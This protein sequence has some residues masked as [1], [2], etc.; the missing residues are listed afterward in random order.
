MKWFLVGVTFLL[1]TVV[2]VVAAAPPSRPGVE[3]PMRPSMDSGL[4]GMMEQDARMIERMNV[5]EMP[6]MGTMI[7]RDPMWVDPAMIRAQEQ[8]QSQ[9]DRMIAR[10]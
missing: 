1:L 7:E 3:P 8:Y 2:V 5:S 9:L 4:D 10:R 6:F